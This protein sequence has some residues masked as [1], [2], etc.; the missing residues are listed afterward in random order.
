MAEALARGFHMDTIGIDF[1]TPDITKSWREIPCAV[2]EING[3]PGIFFDQRIKKILDA[4]FPKEH[5]GRIPTI[6]LVSPPS[7]YSESVCQIL[8]D[9]NKFVGYTDSSS[10]MMNGQ[11][12]CQ[13]KDPLHSRIDAL[14]S[15]PYCETIVIKM[16]I[17][18]LTKLGMPLDW[19]DVILT[20]KPIS[21]RLM[22]L[23]RNHSTHY[24]DHHP[25]PSELMSTLIKIKRHI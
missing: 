24:A 22:E 20:F 18:E 16:S 17:D 8:S 4:R 15:D 12:R 25:N 1:I 13:Q 6:L 9:N 3:S 10:T 19:I 21:N 23:L 2:I 7:G 14:I 5:D 11:S